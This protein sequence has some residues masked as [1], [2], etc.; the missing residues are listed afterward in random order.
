MEGEFSNLSEITAVSLA[1]F[2]IPFI[3]L[4]KNKKAESSIFAKEGFFM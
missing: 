1:L 4:H 2:Q 3:Y